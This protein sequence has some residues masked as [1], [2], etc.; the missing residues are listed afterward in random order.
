MR[1]EV[2]TPNCGGSNLHLTRVCGPNKHAATVSKLTQMW[3]RAQQVA[4]YLAVL[5][6]VAFQGVSV[7]IPS[8][9]SSARSD[10]IALALFGV[11]F[12]ALVRF[13]DGRLPSQ[14]RLNAVVAQ[15]L[16]KAVNTLFEPAFVQSVKI[17][18]YT[19]QRYHPAIHSRQLHIGRLEVC[20]VNPSFAEQC[21]AL[22]DD[23][24][25]RVVNS[26]QYWI[27]QWTTLGSE[28]ASDF[29]LVLY[30]FWPT[31]HYALTGSAGIL[32][33]FSFS[34]ETATKHIEGSELLH[35]QSR[36]GEGSS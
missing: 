9:Q 21:P 31:V 12:L 32:G 10:H 26:L 3:I 4:I 16:P 17:F 6:F 28:R 5:L 13:I 29:R 18:A 14:D 7:A 25:Q 34:A 8:V 33:L 35:K 11:A 24:R 36:T 30:D 20:V 15:D 19:G 1:H 22:T 27:D 23:A 2:D